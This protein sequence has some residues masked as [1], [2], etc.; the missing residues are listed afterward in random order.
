MGVN[1]LR[2]REIKLVYC[3]L[4]SQIPLKNERIEI[5]I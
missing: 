1:T 2:H 4:F 3:L 5:G